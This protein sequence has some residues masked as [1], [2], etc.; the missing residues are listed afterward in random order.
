MEYENTMYLVLQ[1]VYLRV[2]NKFKKKG[3]CKIWYEGNLFL[4]G[5]H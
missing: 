5:K 4:W 2:N 1:K 3:V